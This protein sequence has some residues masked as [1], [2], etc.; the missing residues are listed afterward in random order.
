MGNNFFAE[1]L[2]I[3][4]TLKGLAS[5]KHPTKNSN[6][7]GSPQYAE[8]EWYLTRYGSVA[9][10]IKFY[11]RHDQWDAALSLLRQRQLEPELFIESILLPAYR[12]SSQDQLKTEM[13]AVDPSLETFDVSSF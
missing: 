12:S 3:L 4:S 13:L 10:L 1:V 9:G 5:G 11:L 7:P 6:G 2:E 8:Q